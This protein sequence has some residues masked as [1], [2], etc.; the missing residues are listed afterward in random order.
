MSGWTTDSNTGFGLLGFG[1][2]PFHTIAIIRITA[3]LSVEQT[4]EELPPSFAGP[5]KKGKKKVHSTCLSLPRGRGY[6]PLHLP[7][8][9]A[10]QTSGYLEDEDNG[11][12]LLLSRR[13]RWVRKAG[14]RGL[15]FL[16]SNVFD[17]SVFF[18]TTLKQHILS[19]IIKN[20]AGA[21]RQMPPLLVIP[22]LK[23][24]Y[25]YGMKS[26]HSGGIT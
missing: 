5:I 19:I 25:I 9:R 22:V 21:F 12:L 26:R 17:L 4:H 13:F 20:I 16:F 18:F 7:A 2:A 11:G 14:L 3:T 1:S 23:A 15:P 6:C 10:H 8:S 24:A